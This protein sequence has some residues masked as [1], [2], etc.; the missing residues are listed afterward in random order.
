MEGLLLIDSLSARS[1][2]STLSAPELCV[3]GVDGVREAG[4]IWSES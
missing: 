4:P 1:A 3:L 2:L